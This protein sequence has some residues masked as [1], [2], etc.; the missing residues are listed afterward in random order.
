MNIYVKD[1]ISPGDRDHLVKDLCAQIVQEDP[2]EDFIL[3]FRSPLLQLQRRNSREHGIVV[4]FTEAKNEFLRQKLSRKKDLLARAIGA[5][6]GLR[7]CDLTLG[8]AG[9]SFKLCFFGATVTGYE[10][11]QK[12]WAL[13]QNAVWRFK[14]AGESIALKPIHRN[15]SESFSQELLINDVFYLD[16][17]YTHERSALPRKEMQYLAEITNSTSEEA[18]KLVIESVRQTKKKL[19]V[20]RAPQAEFL[21]GIK[22]RRSVEGK[23]VRF[24][25][26]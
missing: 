26:Y 23:M 8:L 1:P 16:P 4:D 25:I 21:C 14:N 9:D 3:A 6:P 17:M 19:V 15:F 13:V 20:K 24:D 12:L 11:N 10:E 5:E 22:P 18:M 7:I 2:E